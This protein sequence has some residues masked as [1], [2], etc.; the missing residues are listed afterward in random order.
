MREWVSAMARAKQVIQKS[1][2]SRRPLWQVVLWLGVICAA[3]YGWTLGFPMVFDDITYLKMNPL[4]RAE[5]FGYPTRF[6]EFATWPQKNG[7]DPDLAVNFITRPVAYGS[8][9]LNHLWQEYEPQTYGSGIS[10][11]T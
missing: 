7:M 6:I 10:S 4:F 1:S 9:Y 5:S 2:S 11:S 8:F 3:L